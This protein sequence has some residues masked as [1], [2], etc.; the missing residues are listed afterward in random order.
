VRSL[1]VLIFGAGQI[2]QVFADYLASA[3]EPTRIVDA[4]YEGNE[5]RICHFSMCEKWFRPQNHCFMIGM[6]F[7]GL[8]Q[9][10]AEKFKAMRDKGYAPY[11]HIDPGARVSVK[12]NV[13]AGSFVMEQNVLQ[14]GVEVGE[15][16]ILWAGS[17]FGHH[18]KIGNHV[19]V[20]SHAVVSGACEIGDYTFIGVNATIADGVKVGARNV[21]GAGALIL[22][23]TPD[24]A[25]YGA[26]ATPKSP[27]PSYKLKGIWAQ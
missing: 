23:D 10:R 5:I 20:A 13:G 25:V 6:S 24:D 16:C 27:V 8:N 7:K 21:I 14:A 11:I 12:A 22:K 15:N 2:A 9:P 3:A 19:F 1:K 17:H 4:G 18:C 26:V